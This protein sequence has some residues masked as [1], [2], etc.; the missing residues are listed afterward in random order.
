MSD[1]GGTP[2][3]MQPPPEPLL[4]ADDIQGNI[5]PGFMKP[6]MALAVLSIDD[7]A[8]ARK[9]IG[10]IADRITTLRQ[11]MVSRV[12]V[13]RHRTLQPTRELLGTIPEDVRDAFVNIGFSYDALK[14][15][16]GSSSVEDFEDEAFRA[17]LPARA[18]LLGDPVDPSA[19]G[20][21]AN[22]VVGK[23][24]TSPDVMLVFQ[25]D[26]EKDL[27]AL[28][29]D[30]KQNATQNGMTLE[31]EERGY[32]LN[33]D[34]TSKEHFGIKDGISQ[35][36]VRGVVEGGPEKYITPRTIAAE[37]V[38]ETYMYG[39]PGQ[40]L[41]WPGEF[42]FG[43]P[44]QGADPLVPG[45]VNAPGPPWSHNGSYLVFRRLRQDV[46]S[47]WR[48]AK[49]QANI[50]STEPGFEGMDPIRLAASLFGRW[51]SGA[52]VVRTPDKDIPELGA[53]RLA[54][55]HF[56]YASATAPLPL[57][58]GGMTNHFPEAPADPIGLACPLAA[59]TRKVNTREVSN[60]QGGRRASFD[61]RLLR[62]GLSYGSPL[63]DQTGTDPE[64]GNRGLLFISYQASITD[65][66]EF[67][68]HSWMNDNDAPR[69]PSG[70]DMIVGQNGRPGQGRIKTCT[71]L[72]TGGNAA[73]LSTAKDFVIPTGGGYFF[74]PSV[75]ALKD[76]LGT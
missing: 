32:K 20:N 40:Y 9:W 17:G 37:A 57:N 63:D 19:E 7:V 64:N 76:V 30:V 29:E 52:P 3:G 67:L 23:P 71:L 39:L 59:H 75:S 42:V 48:F 53:D 13:R 61:R 21:P 69:S 70:S 43:Y 35:P 5:I 26:Y 68:C 12:K 41:V 1:P 60:D 8:A 44:A 36:G 46:V 4:A 2:L 49:E 31:Y 11:S 27:V 55:N 62:R 73:T 65:Q 56:G 34:G 10:L 50:L 25:A 28:L 22:W 33:P 74:S 47:F 66:F 18:A 45:N 72:G 15:L 58:E 14:K 54:N 6:Y 38:P 51:P 16:V 24:G